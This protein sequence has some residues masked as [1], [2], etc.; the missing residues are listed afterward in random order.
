[1]RTAALERMVRRTDARREEA[2]NHCGLCLAQVPEQ[3]RHLLETGERRVMCVCRACALLFDKDA[4]SRGHY[5]LIP[6]RRV[7]LAPVPTAAL[8]VPVGLA[9]FVPRGEE[10]I[11]HYPSPLGATEWEVDR[12]AWRQLVGRCQELDGLRPD[13]EAL[14]VD[15]AH[16]RS[17]HWIVPV[18]DCFRLIAIVRQEWRGLSGGSTVW[19][20]IGRFFDQL[21]ERRD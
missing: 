3:H 20:A 5:R 19:P 21:T 7:R 9:F 8:G 18:D 16:D 10:V 15:T 11:A 2:A 1:M 13:V 4:A 14:L 6:E 17:D 12:E